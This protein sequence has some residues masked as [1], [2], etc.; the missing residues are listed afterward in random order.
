MVSLLSEDDVLFTDMRSAGNII[1]LRNGTLEDRTETTI[2][3]EEIDPG[4]LP[5]GC[6][7]LVNDSMKALLVEGFQYT[8]PSYFETTDPNWNLIWEKP[9]ARIYRV[10]SSDSD[11]TGGKIE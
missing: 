1:Y 6:F 10:G 3:F 2:P 11:D 5:D 4:S 8:P 7:I 9:Q